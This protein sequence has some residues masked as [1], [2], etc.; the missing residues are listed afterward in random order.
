MEKQRSDNNIVVLLS[1]LLA[2]YVHRLKCFRWK[3]GNIPSGE[4]NNVWIRI[5]SCKLKP[6]VVPDTPFSND[7]QH[8]TTTAAQINNADLTA[9][10]VI[11]QQMAKS[12]YG[13]IIA[14]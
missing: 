1:K 11:P 2:E 9:S 6:E 5:Y 7:A 13:N 8:I 12:M 10:I 3:L 4:G 14:A